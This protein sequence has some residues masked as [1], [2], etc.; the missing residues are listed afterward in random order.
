MKIPAK[1]VQE[2]RNKTG[3]GMMDCKKA[4]QSSDGNM[5]LAIEALRKKG[6]ALADKKANRIAA[7]GIIE[8]Y[9]HAGS[10]IGVLVEINCETDF[11]ARRSEFQNLAKDLAMQIVACPSVQY[12]S[13][14]NIDHSIIE[15]ETRIESEKEDLL[16]KPVDIKE[17][18]VSGRIEKRLKEMSLMNQP[19]IKNTDISIEELI[20]Q[21]IALL[22]ENI[23]VRRFEKFLLGEGLE[24][25]EDN[26]LTDVEN[27]IN[28]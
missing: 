20:K 26:F 7:E 27:I 16:N 14:D 8:S 10:R 25:K 23:K 13:V 19:F 9:I 11:V 6:L 24:K 4:L 2:L 12:I 18:I 17:K 21:H 15:F 1:F 3:A 28:K 5:E 22:G